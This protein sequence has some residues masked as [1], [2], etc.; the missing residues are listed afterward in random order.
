[1]SEHDDYLWNR[2]GAVDPETA[3][4]ER[5]LRSYAHDASARPARIGAVPRVDARRPR[6]RLRIAFA[7][8]AVLGLCAVGLQ[9]WYAQR[10]QWQAGRPWQVVAQQ[11][12][13]RIGDRLASNARAFA[14]GDTLHT[15]RNATVRLQAARIG[16][17]A[18]AGD[19]RLRL[20]ETRTGRHRLQLLEGRMWARV[21][22]P[23][24]QFGVGVPG[25]EVLDLGCE[26][27]IDAEA[28]GSGTI[29]VRSGWVQVDTGMHEVLVPQGASV[30]LRAGAPPGT[31]RDRRASAAFVA[32]L[33]T[34]DAQAGQVDP[35][36]EQMQRLVAASRA[37]DAISLVSLAQRHP[38]LVEGPLHER[39]LEFL[40]NA[41]LV[42]RADFRAR[43]GMATTPWWDALPYPRIKRWWMQWPDALPAGGRAQS[44]LRENDG[45]TR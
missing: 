4:L 39:I 19:S 37:S 33:D 14:V 20:V 5:L 11:G 25:A 16:E 21:W 30:R 36:G 31:P 9:A 22:A 35:R 29:A 41:T 18:L 17:I 6:R 23:P 27:V 12:E 45:A 38:P 28:D 42:T 24:G 40:P 34:I 26:F 1:M 43:G 15:G 3:R 8:A 44:W 32:A 7:A 10:L 13:V 2:S